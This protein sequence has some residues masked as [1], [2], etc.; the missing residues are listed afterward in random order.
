MFEHILNK[1]RAIVK[2]NL[3][4]IGTMLVIAFLTWVLSRW[5][6]RAA[7]RLLDHSQHLFESEERP[8]EVGSPPTG[9]PAKRRQHISPLVKKQIAARQKWRCAI[10]HRLLDETYE[11]DHIKPLFKGGTNAIHNLQ[12]L[13]KSDHMSKSAMES[14][15]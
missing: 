1:D 12:A 6:P 8:R 10:C 15:A 5:D 11:I 2:M 13:C 3:A 9:S 4:V 7:Y 14:I